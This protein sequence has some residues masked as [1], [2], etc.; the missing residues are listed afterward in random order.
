MQNL[1][2]EVQLHKEK[3]NLKK[4]SCMTLPIVF[5][6]QEDKYKQK[7]E[8]LKAKI[9]SLH[10]D[11]ECAG[12]EILTQNVPRTQGEV[13]LLAKT[14]FKDIDTQAVTNPHE[15]QTKVEEL[16]K[17]KKELKVKI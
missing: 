5:I 15:E 6:A 16:L 1:N 17:L 13:D 14:T 2:E 7:I 9:E 11:L 3:L 10:A 8:N 4:L 12:L